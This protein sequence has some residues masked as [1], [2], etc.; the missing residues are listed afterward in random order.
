VQ[1]ALPGRGT[2]PQLM[3]AA[4]L[5]CVA[6]LPLQQ[7]ACPQSTAGTL[8]VAT[9]ARVAG[10]S[11][12]CL[13]LRASATPQQRRGA[14]AAVMAAPLQVL[15]LLLLLPEMAEQAQ[16]EKMVVVVVVVLVVLL[17]LLELLVLVGVAG[18]VNPLLGQDERQWGIWHA[19]VTL[20]VAA[21]FRFLCF[22]QT[23]RLASLTLAWPVQL[24]A[25]VVVVVV[26]EEEEAV[27][28]VVTKKIEFAVVVVEG[29][30][31]FLLEAPLPVLPIQAM[32]LLVHSPIASTG[33]YEG[34]GASE[35]AFLKKQHKNAFLKKVCV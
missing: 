3:K 10:P 22:Q 11:G 17:L 32:A 26:G 14:S 29:D 23:V 9:S 16:E 12:S 2:T 34:V 35:W 8:A 6:Q 33:F 21:I 5:P 25:W 24:A 15:R 30:R 13:Q 1:P 28:V 4:W 7:E 19:W 31:R 18:V 20:A 27:V